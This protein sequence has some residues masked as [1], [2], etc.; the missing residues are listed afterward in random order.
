MSDRSEDNHRGTQ[1]NSDSDQQ[2]ETTQY[3]WGSWVS[4]EN[5]ISK[6]TPETY[7]LPPIG[8]DP[9]EYGSRVPVETDTNYPVEPD[10]IIGIGIFVVLLG[11]VAVISSQ[12]MGWESMSVLSG[13]LT[14]GVWIIAALFL[15]SGVSWLRNVV[16][17]WVTDYPTPEHGPEEIQVRILT[18]DAEGIVQ[19][20]VDHLP[21]SLTNR[22]VIAE[23]DME[24]DGAEVHV[25]PEEFDCVATNK[26]RAIEWA[27]QHIPCERE[28]VLYLDEDTL[29][30]DFEE[31]P[32]ADIVQ[33]REWPMKTDSWWTYWAEIIRMGFQV[34]QVGYTDRDIPL[35]AWG[36]G[37]A[38]RK[39]VEDEITWD[40]DTLIEDTVF[41]WFAVQNGADYVV[42]KTRFR[43]QAPLSVR[44]MIDQRQRWVV[45][46]IRE[47]EYL[48]LP[49]QLLMTVRN[50]VWVFSPII[51]LVSL[52]IVLAWVLGVPTGIEW[53]TPLQVGS[54][55]LL[56]LTFLWVLTGIAYY[57]VR[58]QTIPV[59]GL[60]WI[61]IVLHSLGAM[62]GFVFPPRT[63]KAT[64]KTTGGS[65]QPGDQNIKDEPD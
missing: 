39:S 19:R 5:I 38:V 49:N 37:L 1:E 15:V 34:G 52:L 16:V 61:L 9:R 58:L 8:E 55:A 18:I 28:Y 26:G 53:S 36:G 22:H 14:I 30:K 57:G 54:A 4:P 60:W 40:F 64:E 65:T 23:S 2:E 43:N 17:G 6:F 21:E 51:A 50:L 32:D 3:T 29:I 24:I 56:A 20:T 47:E 7:P 41:T 35:Y 33:F 48:S 42:V 45:G 31:L 10:R 25:V 59:L 63:F 62:K 27:R 46:T 13:I 11:I 44:D 12:M